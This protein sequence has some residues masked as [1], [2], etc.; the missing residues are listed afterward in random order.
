MTSPCF[1]CE[2]RTQTC[3]GKDSDCP[4]KEKRDAF[5]AERQAKSAELLFDRKCNDILF[6]GIGITQKKT[7]KRRTEQL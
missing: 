7:A 2:H 5:T 3:H 1:L 6:G 4:R